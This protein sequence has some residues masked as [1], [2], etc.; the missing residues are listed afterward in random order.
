MYAVGRQ[1]E[2]QPLG[3]RVQ[4]DYDALIVLEICDRAAG[5][6]RRA[7]GDRRIVAAQIRWIRRRKQKDSAQLALE[8]LLSRKAQRSASKRQE[9]IN[10]SK[11]AQA[12]NGC[13]I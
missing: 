6:D 11:Q 10:E 9:H 1:V 3:L 5:N 7:G 13:E 4:L 8:N 2:S 12:I